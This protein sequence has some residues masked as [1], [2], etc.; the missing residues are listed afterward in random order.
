[1]NSNGNKEG[2]TSSVFRKTINKTIYSV[3]IRFSENAKETMKDK[4]NR[5]IRSEVREFLQYGLK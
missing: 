5:M 1:M 2:N 3:K 4:V